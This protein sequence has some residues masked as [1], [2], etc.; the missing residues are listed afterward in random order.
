MKIIVIFIEK[1]S[2]DIKLLELSA[3]EFISFDQENDY[4]VQHLVVVHSQF[5]AL[6]KNNLKFMCSLHLDWC[7][8][9]LIKEYGEEIFTET[10]EIK[11][12]TEHVHRGNI[13]CMACSEEKK[14]SLPIKYE[15][16]IS[17]QY[18]REKLQHFLGLLKDD[19]LSK[20]DLQETIDELT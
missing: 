6:R 20:E 5:R 14:S 15:E 13:F 8:D 17:K 16:L 12:C 19:M 4:R 11:I 10:K 3:K 1:E 9:R 18:F 2:S 7:A